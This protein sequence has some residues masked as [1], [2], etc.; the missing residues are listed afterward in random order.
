MRLE[1]FR[2]MHFFVTE[3]CFAQ[4]F[5]L[6]LELDEFFHAFALN[7]NFWSF[8]VNGDRQLV[9]LGEENRVRFG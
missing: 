9:F 6:Q 8:F 1:H 2:G 7:E 3:L 4:N 5:W